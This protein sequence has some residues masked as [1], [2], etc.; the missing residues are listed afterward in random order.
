ME[1]LET[2][3]II[4][5]DGV[6][7]LCDRFVNFVYLRDPQKRFYY[8]P[9]QGPTAQ[10]LLGEEANLKSIVYFKQGIVL[11][12]VEGVREIVK[13]IYPR[14][15]WLFKILPLSFYNFFYNFIAKKR[16]K[17]FGK[18]NQLYVPSEEQKKSFLP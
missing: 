2:K 17:I 15:V 11:R 16:Y 10:K 3:D 8:A 14:W 13:V 4:F 1:S 6:C 7:N 9:L 5:F 12:G 18:K